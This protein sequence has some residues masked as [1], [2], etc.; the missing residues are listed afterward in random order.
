MLPRTACFMLLLALGSEKF[1]LV[2]VSADDHEEPNG[3]PEYH[4]E[5]LLDDGGEGLDPGDDP[6]LSPDGL[7]PDGL[8]DDDDL[9]PPSDTNTSTVFPPTS[10]GRELVP[11]VSYTQAEKCGFEQVGTCAENF[12]KC[13]SGNLSSKGVEPLNG[14]TGGACGSGHVSNCYLLHHCAR[15]RTMCIWAASRSYEDAAKD[16]MWDMSRMPEKWRTNSGT[17]S[18]FCRGLLSIS[19]NLTKASA[20]VNF[21]DTPFYTDCAEYMSFLFKRSGGY[22]CLAG[23]VPMYVCGPLL[24][25]TPAPRQIGYAPVTNGSRRLLVTVAAYF[26]G[27]FAVLFND[28]TRGENLQIGSGFNKEFGNELHKC[29]REYVGIDGEFTMVHGGPNLIVKYVIGLGEADT[30]VGD[31]IKANALNLM[32]R[33]PGWMATAQDILRTIDSNAELVAPIVK[34][35]VN[36][37]PGKGPVFTELCDV[38]CAV[39]LSVSGALSA[40]VYLLAGIFC[41]QRNKRTLAS[42]DSSSDVDNETMET[43]NGALSKP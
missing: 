22:M 5:E 31:L 29:F 25:P 16:A 33:P 7:P 34:Y 24:F 39:A 23:S 4:D 10:L 2:S 42:V 35:T 8:D 18:S 36:F 32:V 40:A 27:N 14:M 19:R 1:R 13:L 37:D 20:D 41:C 30:W 26:V 12:C 28:R 11:D 15:E 3:L 21:Y 17:N 9:P 38:G 6:S 43:A